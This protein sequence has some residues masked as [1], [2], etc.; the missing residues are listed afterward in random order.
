LDPVFLASLSANDAEVA[1]GV[2]FDADG[3]RRWASR[4]VEATEAVVARNVISASIARPRELRIRFSVPYPISFRLDRLLADELQLSRNRIHGLEKSK[5]L[6]VVAS[7][8]ARMLRKPV[9]DGMEVQLRLPVDG[10]E[11]IVRRAACDDAVWQ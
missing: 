5:A 9:R 11:W 8:S 7:N 10:A 3:L 4:L 6:V 1:A 2:A